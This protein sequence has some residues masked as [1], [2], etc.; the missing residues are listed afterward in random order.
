MPCVS[1][2]NA[3]VCST[4]V[5][6]IVRRILP[7]PTCKRRR[8]MVVVYGW[9]VWYGPTITCCACGDSWADGERLMRPAKRGWR[10]EAA[11]KAKQKWQNAFQ[12]T[13][14]ERATWLAWGL[15]DDEDDCPPRR[16]E[17][18]TV[19]VKGGVL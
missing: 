19:A 6:E 13:D 5:R 16:R 3:S 9:S 7:C 8:R 18:E 15:S 11:A 10:Q 1:V 17:V 4:G 2:G 12:M 14:E